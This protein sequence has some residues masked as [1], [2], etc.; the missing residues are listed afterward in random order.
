MSVAESLQVFGTVVQTAKQQGLTVRGYV[1]TVIDCP[2][3]GRIAPDAV[4]P[5]IAAL[6]E[7][8]CDE[9]SLGETLGTAVPADITHLLKACQQAGLPFTQLAFHAHDTY[10]M[11]IANVQA[12]LEAG[13]TTLD[14]SAG[15]LGGCPYAPG[16]S[17]NV[18]TED[19]VYLL[20]QQGIQTGIDLNTLCQTSHWFGNTTGL[21]LPSKVLKAF[22]SPCA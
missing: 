22:S 21:T 7:M 13:I 3:T 16:A 8:G 9:V 14:S 4:I 5:T 6:L 18:A 10:G 17:G 15:G 19:V 12:A 1:S 2:Y 11:G 20:N